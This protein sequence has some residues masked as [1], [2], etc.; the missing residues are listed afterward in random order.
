[1]ELTERNNEAGSGSHSKIFEGFLDLSN[2]KIDLGS[3]EVSG[4]LTFDN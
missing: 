3:L 2:E 4:K 1:M